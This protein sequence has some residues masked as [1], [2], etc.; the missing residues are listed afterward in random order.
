M[1]KD[2]YMVIIDNDLGPIQ[3]GIG[4]SRFNFIGM[5]IV[6]P[7]FLYYMYTRP[8]PRKIYTDVLADKGA[9]GTYV[10]ECLATKKPTLWNKISAQLAKNG[11]DFP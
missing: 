3:R 2:G 8:V 1:L 5:T 7:I 6:Y 10:R 4:S 11:F 9:D